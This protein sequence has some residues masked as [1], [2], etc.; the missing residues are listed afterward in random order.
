MAF[1]ELTE[2][3]VKSIVKKV[4]VVKNILRLQRSVMQPAPTPVS[5]DY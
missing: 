1:C 2:E 3:D 5:C 4:G